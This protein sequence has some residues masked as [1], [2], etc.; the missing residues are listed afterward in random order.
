[1]RVL[2]VDLKPSLTE[3]WKVEFESY[4]E[5][6]V[7]CT[8]YFTY[9]TDAMVSPANSFGFMDGGLDL[10]IRTKLGID[11]EA[12]VKQLIVGKYH[13]EMPVGVAEILATG[14]KSWPFLVVAPTMRIPERVAET[15]NA[16]VAFRAILLAVR[17]FAHIN[18]LLVPGLATGCGAMDS[19]K[20]A[21]Q[22][23]L[24]YQQV[25]GPPDTPSIR[26]IYK[27]NQMLK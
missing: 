24:A 22:M 19:E 7:H 1:M 9:P 4:D 2:L 26:D 25:Q 23:L 18:T 10:P 8:D 27:T 17:R 16:Y 20:C 3:A 13:G 21:R 11:I 6:T 12:K 15:C 5:V 14:H